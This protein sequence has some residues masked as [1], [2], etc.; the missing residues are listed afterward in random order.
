[1]SFVVARPIEGITINGLEFLLDDEGE[2]LLFES[3]DE[4]KQFLTEHGETLNSEEMD[5]AYVF[6]DPNTDD[7][8]YKEYF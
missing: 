3:K 7:P 2:M 8:L 4:A 6:I 5:E 1:M